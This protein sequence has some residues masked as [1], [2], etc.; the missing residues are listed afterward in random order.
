[1]KNKDQEIKK[2]IRTYEDLYIACAV[3]I[4]LELMQV[5][6]PTDHDRIISTS[7]ANK[8]KK[9]RLEALEI[10][11]KMYPEEKDIFRLPHLKDMKIKRK[12]GSK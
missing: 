9:L 12:G 10:R 2:L 5:Q 11:D 6:D 7:L 8:I 1:M 4:P 3:N